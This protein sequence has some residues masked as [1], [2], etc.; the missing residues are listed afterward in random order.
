MNSLRLCLL[1]ASVQLFCATVRADQQP[2]P[3]RDK[4]NF[5][6]LG[7]RWGGDPSGTAVMRGIVD[8][9]NRL[10]PDFCIS[11]GDLIPGYTADPKKL[12]GM[13]DHLRKEIGRLTVKF[14]A[15]PGN[16]DIFDLPSRDAW[17]RHW[18]KLYYSFDY[19]NAHFVVLNSEDALNKN[20]ILGPQR[21]WLEKD[22]SAFR[23]R[24]PDGPI[25][26]FFHKPLWRYPTSG[27]LEQVQPI[28]AR[29][30]VHTVFCGHWHS[31]A[32]GKTRDGV[33]YVMIGSSGGYQGEHEALGSF[34]QYGHVTVEGNKVTLAV[35]KAGG[36]KGDR[37]NTFKDLLEGRQLSRFPFHVE[38]LPKGGVPLGS[39]K[40]VRLLLTN[41]LGSAVKLTLRWTVDARIWKMD[42]PMQQV[43]LD[44]NQRKT[45][46]FQ[47]T[48]L[49]EGR[50]P[51][52]TVQLEVPY[53]TQS[54]RSVTLRSSS[55]L[56]QRRQLSCR[57]GEPKQLDG[58]VDDW[59]GVPA[60]A[61][62]PGP[63]RPI[64]FAMTLQ[65]AADKDYL[66]L[67]V[68]CRDDRLVFDPKS[69]LPYQNDSFLL[70]FDTSGKG[71]LKTDPKLHQAFAALAL[72]PGG[73]MF[74]VYGKGASI[75][76]PYAGAGMTA[77]RV[78]GGYFAE[79]KIPWSALGVQA[80]KPG[81]RWKFN[82]AGVDQDPGRPFK[83]HMWSPRTPSFWGE[84]R[85]DEAR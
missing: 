42:P 64:D 49:A 7:D 8:E 1:L 25:F 80:P 9:I 39:S 61:I 54:G 26:V 21:E 14:M 44:G 81:A 28:L 2:P 41:P 79:G 38:P 66:Y 33:R 48:R 19:R 76:K 52:P 67:A 27:F 47:L 74:K 53:V 35:I 43:Q 51:A 70:T 56:G 55:K 16:H 59:N 36:I 15:V 85:F 78:P 68:R 71:G 73:G 3:L 40:R 84:L 13:Y 60:V 32:K 10:Q 6:I 23:K 77:R 20:K 24:R 62:E 11:V 17:V 22:L 82:F 18:G 46:D 31:Y 69:P 72:R 83:I 50:A 63:E 57:F 65:L 4:F 75:L 34:F 5:T 45:V 37:H 58:K 29:H 30:K 12:A